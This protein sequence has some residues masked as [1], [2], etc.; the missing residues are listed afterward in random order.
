L[1]GLQTKGRAALILRVQPIVRRVLTIAW[2]VWG[3]DLLT[4]RLAQRYLE[5]AEP[6]QIVGNFLKLTFTRNSGA[7]FSFIS[8]GT[9]LLGAFAV[10]AILVIAFWTPRLTSG[11]WAYV[12]GLV[13]GGALG[14]LTDRVFRGTGGFLKGQVVDWI[15][16]PH[17]PIFNLADSAIVIAAL[18]AI[19]LSIRNVLPISRPNDG[20]MNE[21]GSHDA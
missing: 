17:W 16:L 20:D 13:L 1:Y 10:M 15:Q 8:Q 4:K 12:F 5:G 2:L 9:T 18:I 6:K 19:F 14:N 7:A 11:P 3:L 21:K